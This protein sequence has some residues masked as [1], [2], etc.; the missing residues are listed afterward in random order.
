MP[1][2]VVH[3]S[4]APADHPVLSQLEAEGFEL[5][6]CP[7]ARTLIEEVMQRVPDALIYALP[8]DCREDLGV[9]RLMRRAAP[10]VPLVLLAT[11]DSLETRRTTQAL[12][13][14]YYAVCPIDGAELCQVM[15][16]AVARRGRVY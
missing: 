10:N 4:A 5:V 3:A 11:E 2:V 7:D 6:T 12:R 14:I 1:R 16:N 13:P 8:A 15:R 9:L